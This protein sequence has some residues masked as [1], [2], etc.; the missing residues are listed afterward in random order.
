MALGRAVL[1]LQDLEV[2]NVG[3]FGVHIELDA[4]HGDIAE[5]AV[6]HL[7]KSSPGARNR[8][9][10]FTSAPRAYRDAVQKRV[11][12]IGTEEGRWL[13]GSRAVRT[14]YHIAQP[15]LC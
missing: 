8:R 3:I 6:E 5:D 7:A 10:A 13:P 9:L 14:Q 1:T 11:G 4:S 2:L 12:R 15:L